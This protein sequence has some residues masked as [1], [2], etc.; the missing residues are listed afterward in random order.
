M[1]CEEILSLRAL[2]GLR[3]LNIDYGCM[4][5]PTQVLGFLPQHLVRLLRNLPSLREFML[6]LEW[7]CS[8]N[9]T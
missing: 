7:G 6:L 1:H 5:A 9:R 3:E 4:V 2:T 8:N